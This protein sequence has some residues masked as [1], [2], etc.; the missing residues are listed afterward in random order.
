MLGELWVRSANFPRRR[1]QLL[2]GCQQGVAWIERA[3]LS[4]EMRH[5]LTSMIAIEKSENHCQPSPLHEEHVHEHGLNNL[6]FRRLWQ[7]GWSLE[8]VCLAVLSPP[9]RMTV[10]L[11]F[12]TCPMAA[13]HGWNVPVDLPCWLLQA[14]ETAMSFHCLLRQLLPERGRLVTPLNLEALLSAMTAVLAAADIAQQQG[15]MREANVLMAG[16]NLTSLIRRFARTLQMST[17]ATVPENVEYYLREL[18][19][20]TLD[21]SA[22]LLTH[23]NGRC[24]VT[25][26]FCL[27]LGEIW[28]HAW[29]QAQTLLPAFVDEWSEKWN[30]LSMQVAE[31]LGSGTL[32]LLEPVSALFVGEQT[33]PEN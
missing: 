22:L 30:H 21:C 28:R 29:L 24:L 31:T 16:E 15:G 20:W 26:P 27:A 13:K 6:S 9:Q 8:P 1:C 10:L 33:R 5:H 25:R 7:L 3:H 2:E 11:T 14:P 18:L 19:Q 32:T 23:E 4:P 17:C 12:P